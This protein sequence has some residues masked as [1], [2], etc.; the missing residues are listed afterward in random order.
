M[1]RNIIGA[2]LG[3]SLL[4]NL[5]L[6]GLYFWD[7]AQ[8]P[9]PVGQPTLAPTK[10]LPPP[11][12]S[13]GA[14]ATASAAA[15]APTSPPPAPTNPPQPTDVPIAEPTLA[16]T[17]SAPPTAAPTTAP[18]TPVI[19]GPEWLQY[20]NLFRAQAGLPPVTENQQWSI[21]GSLHSRYMSNTG[22]LDHGED[23]VSP[24]YTNEGHAAGQNGNIAATLITMPP[25]KWAFNYWMSAAF[26]ALPMID[27]E[28]QVVGFAEYRDPAAAIEV[29]GTLDI[30]RG[31]G[32]MPASVKFPIMFPKDGGLTWVLRYSLPEFPFAL[33]SCPGYAQPSGPPI[34]L[35]IGKGDLTPGVTG[36]ALTQGDKQLPHCEIDETNYFNPDG[37]FQKSGRRIIGERDAIILIPQ[38]PLEPD[39]TYTVRVD[40]NGASY[41]WSFSTAKGPVGQ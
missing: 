36:T 19:T 8:T 40:V 21:D 4:V 10:E 38:S 5:I 30:K 39:K 14:A 41:T 11:R 31:L 25:Y 15:V 9:A 7:A 3:I 27:P 22:Q 35:Q 2:L 32:P 20:L 17:E 6:V 1:T 23:P 29:T 16:P 37:R 18:P 33:S 13:V 28:L 24:F 12:L 34:M 26:H